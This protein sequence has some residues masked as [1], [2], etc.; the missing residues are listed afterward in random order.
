MS[1]SRLSFL[2]L[3]FLELNPLQSNLSNSDTEGTEQIVRIR[4]VSI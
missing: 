3:I 4:E 1:E 2:K